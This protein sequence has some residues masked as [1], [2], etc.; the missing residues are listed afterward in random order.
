MSIDVTNLEM[1]KRIADVLLGAVYA[2]GK[3]ETQE[4]E[5]L[6]RILGELLK[7]E[8]PEELVA[9]LEQF[10]IESFDLE[11][12][13]SE[14]SFDVP[15]ARRNLLKMVAEITEADDIHDLE[16]SAYIKQVANCIGALE[17]EYEDLTVEI[18]S[19]ESI[20]DTPPPP[21]IPGSE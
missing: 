12:V 1:V 2:D 5:A 15:D 4:L 18:L 21:P 6:L 11:R 9:H 19:V 10:D 14:L 3:D 16:E 8:V 7:G 13:C 20:G 17:A